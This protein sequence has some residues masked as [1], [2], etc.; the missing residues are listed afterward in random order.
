M[1]IKAA[2]LASLLFVMTP[3]AMPA[4]DAAN[5][6]SWCYRDFSGPQF[7]NCTFISAQQRIRIAGVIGGVCERNHA[8]PQP[9]KQQKPKQQRKR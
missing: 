9:M 8:P 1:Q 3:G 2:T 7:S 6:G 4:A 5:D